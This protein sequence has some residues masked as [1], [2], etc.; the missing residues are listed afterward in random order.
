[1]AGVC[2]SPVTGH[3]DPAA[4]PTDLAALVDPFVGTG[5]ATVPG[6]D[7]A[8][9]NT[10]PG[11]DTPFGMVQW[12]PDTSPH[13]QP[14]GGYSYADSTI[15]GFSLTHLSGPGCPIYGDVPILPT[16]GPLQPRPAAATARFA[17]QDE[18]ASPGRYAVTLASGVGVD[19]GVTSRT[20]LGRFTYPPTR[21]ARILLKADR[22]AYGVDY[23]DVRIVGSMR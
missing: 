5:A 12:S 13:R 4:A 10:F 18:Q 15:S 23:N 19:L 20:G 8:N 17:H 14:G 2:V 16:I 3:A 9:I 7:P 1:M 6:S 21:S 11:A 22:S